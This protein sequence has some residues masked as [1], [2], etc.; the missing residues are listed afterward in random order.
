MVWKGSFM[1]KET[2]RFIMVGFFNTFHY[3]MW[4]L[5]FTELFS[6]HYLVSHWLGF[7]ISMIGSFYLNTYYTYRTK[8]SWKKFLQFPFTYVVNIAVSS[9]V[10]FLLKDWLAFENWLAP[11]IASGVAIPFTFLLSRKIL[12]GEVGGVG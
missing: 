7:I 3:Y 1:G 5:L 2:I 6:F 8:P 10:L 4:Y 12:R 11:I 9:F